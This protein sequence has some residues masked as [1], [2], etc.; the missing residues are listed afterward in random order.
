MIWV[1]VCKTLPQSNLEQR[2]RESNAEESEGRGHVEPDLAG[3][4][5]LR[6]ESGSEHGGRVPPEQGNPHLRHQPEARHQG[7]APR[8]GPQRSKCRFSR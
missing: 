5:V 4:L 8:R 2:E 6:L 3:D 1:C 7:L